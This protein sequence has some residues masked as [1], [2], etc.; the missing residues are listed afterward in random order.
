[1]AVEINRIGFALAFG[2]DPTTSR[3]RVLSG[4]LRGVWL[5]LQM[6][7]AVHETWPDGANF[8]YI[9]WINDIYAIHAR[10]NGLLDGLKTPM[11]AEGERWAAT[12]PDRGWP[13][14]GDGEQGRIGRSQPF[15]QI[16]QDD[17]AEQQPRPIR[18]STWWP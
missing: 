8:G 6:A 14:A 12:W 1:M 7:D 4:V 10:E 16:G 2:I 15:G 18:A 5:G 13:T 9:H 11:L 17:S 3:L